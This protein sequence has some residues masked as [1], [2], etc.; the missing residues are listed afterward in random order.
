MISSKKVEVV[1]GPYNISS[2][3]ISSGDCHCCYL[4]T[5]SQR[6]KAK[7]YVCICEQLQR[8]WQDL[9]LI[10]QFCNVLLVKAIASFCIYMA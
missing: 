2:D 10:K 4:I 8:L 6:L 1:S 5:L 9:S 7:G 3:F